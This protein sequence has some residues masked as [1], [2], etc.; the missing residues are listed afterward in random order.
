MCARFYCILPYFFSIS[1]SR[2]APTVAMAQNHSCTRPIQEI[3]QECI[4]RVT[5]DNG[6]DRNFEVFHPLSPS[7]SNG[8]LFSSILPYNP[9]LHKHGNKYVRRMNMHQT[10]HVG[11][12]Q[13]NVLYSGLYFTLSDII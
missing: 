7:L 5:D 13:F 1:R 11:L 9:R 8:S 2:N 12:Y 4:P 3:P 6:E 10:T